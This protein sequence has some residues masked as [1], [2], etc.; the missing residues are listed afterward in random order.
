MMRL[1]TQM[2][3]YWMMRPKMRQ[4]R[5]LN[6]I[7]FRAEKGCPI[8]GEAMTLFHS[9]IFSV[10]PPFRFPITNDPPFCSPKKQ[11]ISPNPPIPPAPRR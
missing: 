4:T 11:V 7:W 6:G 10:I 3:K 5:L 8:P 2:K 1:K 9:K